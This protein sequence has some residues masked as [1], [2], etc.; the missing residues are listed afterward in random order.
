[1]T[2][3]YLREENTRSMLDKRSPIWLVTV[4]LM[5]WVVA[6]AVVPGAQGPGAQTPAGSTAVNR[7]AVPALDA[8]AAQA[9]VDRYCVTCHNDRTQTAGLSLASADAGNAPVQ[10][11]VWEKVIRKVSAGSMP[12]VG[13]PRPDQATLDG[14]TGFLATSLDRAAAERPD[15]GRPVLHRLNRAEYGN[16]VRDLLALEVPVTALLPP[17]ELSHG[18]D[19]IGEALTIS[20]VLLERYL[21]AADRI[22]ALAVGDPSI[23][24]GTETY[25]ARGDSQ[26][27]EHIDGLPLGTRGGVMVKRNFPLD[28]EYIISA[29]LWRTNNGFTRGLSAAHEVEFSI[30]GERVFSTKVGGQEDWTALLSN[31]AS[32]DRLDSRLQARV[33][34]RAGFHTLGVTFVQ[35]T[36]AR[37]M[38]LY[39]PLLGNTDSVDSDGVP[40]IDV[41]MVS[42][43]FNPTGP[44]DTASRRR[45][46]TCTPQRPADERRCAT[47]I[48]STVARRAFRRPVPA[49]ELATLMAFFDAGRKEGDFDRG[50][51][52]AV[53]RV[54]ADP[55]FLFRAERQPARVTP[56][57]PYRVSD[58]ELASRLSFFLW[59]SIPDDELL[60]LAES[61]RLS[62]TAVYRDQVRRML[63]DPRAD[64]LIA[65]FSGQWLQLRNL[66]RV[67]PNPMEFPDFDDDLRQGFRRETE[68]FFGSIVREDR[69][70]VDLLKADYTFVNGR[71]ARHYGIPGVNGSN[72][73]RVS[74]MQDARKGILGHGSVLTL[75]SHPNRTSPVKRG[76]WVLENLLGSPPP[77]PP[78]NVPPLKEGAELPR[79]KTMK[80]RM[81]EH[82][83]NP[84]CAN[85]H[86]LMDPIGLAMENFDGVGAWRVRDAGTRIDATSQLSDGTAVDGVVALRDSLVR[87]PDVFVRTMTENLLVYALGRGL[88]TADQPTVRAIMREAQPGNY[89]MSALVTGIVNSTPFR[90][91][92]AASTRETE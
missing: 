91:R 90:M 41:V 45:L 80:E 4:T 44:G 74:V 2:W 35:K 3:R 15:P 64:A 53:R 36:G 83:A 47:A 33:P 60:A 89:R 79:P 22:S 32:A 59:S 38:S 10:A 57:R 54:L 7:Q 1:M 39:R 30:D 65:N 63:A 19:N 77:P 14:F 56:G 76:K 86:R 62:S 13:M 78:P 25:P 5:T 50:V 26:Q 12:P 34:I 23:T 11:E 20:P 84:T 70:V 27:L 68:L 9:L 66:E 71:L 55:A 82:R 37:N 48:V 88:T 31:P 40:R 58:I 43:P 16:A 18:F 72:F 73:R 49:A 87:R 92:M 6:V 81:V 61:G 28:G 29:K 8:P 67:A 46:F 69:S 85:C 21:A 51:Q 52:M 24:A 75:T 17:D 42:G